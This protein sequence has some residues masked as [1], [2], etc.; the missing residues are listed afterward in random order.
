MKRIKLLFGTILIVGLAGFL[1]SQQPT[2]EPPKEGTRTDAGGAHTLIDFGKYEE[3]NASAESPYPAN[4]PEGWEKNMAVYSITQK[5]M[6]LNRWVITFNSSSDVYTSRLNSYTKN[7]KTKKGE[8]VL[9]ARIHFPDHSFYSHAA[10]SP[11]YEIMEYN[12][13]GKLVNKNNGVLPNVADIKEISVEASGRNYD[14]KLFLRLMNQDREIKDFYMGS[15]SFTGWRKLTWKN[16]YYIGNVDQRTF[17]RP[18]LYPR[19]IPYYKF[20]SFVVSRPAHGA[21]GDFVVYFKNVKITHDLSSV[22]EDQLSIDDENA[23]GIK[24]HQFIQREAYLKKV[25]GTIRYLRE[26]EARR[27]GR[28]IEDPN[29]QPETKSTEKPKD[30]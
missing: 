19:E 15:L 10:I 3:I 29:E 9:G 22:D 14:N 20:V 7:I 30:K 27:M 8:T 12:S 17:S 5:D 2:G 6:A 26:V 1:F 21:T 11:P 25:N 23:W 24:K 13:K 16:P 4:S 28:N 18:K